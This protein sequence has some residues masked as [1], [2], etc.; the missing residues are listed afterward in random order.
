M[1][2]KLI[3]K[4]G[5]KLGSKLLIVCLTFLV[6]PALGFWYTAEFKRFLKRGQ[7]EALLLSAQAVATLLHDRKDLFYSQPNAPLSVREKDD[8]I[9]PV[10][11]SPPTLDGDENDWGE[12]MANARHFGEE[13]VL[14]AAKNSEPDSDGF[15][16]AVGLY[17][18]DLS[19]F[20][21]V[22]DDNLVF[23]HPNLRRLD[24]CDQIRVVLPDKKGKPANYIIIAEKEGP[25]DAYLVDE[26]WKYALTKRAENKIRGFMKKTGAGYTVEFRLPWKMVALHGK[27]QLSVADVDNHVSR[28]IKRVIGALGQNRSPYLNLIVIRSP[29]LERLFSGLD[30]EESRLTI[31]DRQARVRAQTGHGISGGKVNKFSKRNDEV[32]QAA[33]AGGSLAQT[34][35]SLDKSYE[36][37]MAATPIRAADNTI[38]GV[39][40]IERSTEKIL[41]LKRRGLVRAGWV[42]GA[43]LLL[44]VL[45]LIGFS[46]RLTFRIHRLRDEV[47]NAIDERGRTERDAKFADNQTGDEIGD[48]ARGFENMKNRLGRYTDF[49]ERLPKTLRHEMNNPLNTVSVSL[50]NMDDEKDDERSLKYLQSAQRGVDRLKEIVSRLTEAA[51][52]EEALADEVLYDLDLAK[53]V[54][55]YVAN[56][57][58]TTYKGSIVFTNHASSPFIR[59]SDYK[60]EQLLDKLIDN[61][62][63]FRFKDTKV[64]VSI[65][66]DGQELC[67]S[68]ANDGPIIDDD[69]LDH[70]FDFLARDRKPGAT[71]APHL[72][73]GLYIAQIIAQQH[74]GHISVANKENREGVVFTVWFPHGSL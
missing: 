24:N 44:V 43:A 10:F 3:K 13:S 17:R 2:P 74:G 20:V 15:D 40:L 59:G 26:K 67:L 63:D 22:T 27:F 73:I 16:L 31:I 57:N 4:R 6:I 37:S 30:L 61:A 25:I 9:A 46:S 55:R 50:Q 54:E 72:G 39:A 38:L 12:V 62:S 28:Q 49:L 48:L 70:L 42:T 1:R 69:L 65:T 32:I 47:E 58:A 8:F 36:I 60:I 45:A 51:N 11:E 53:L 52:M 71:G 14:F 5:L 29:E 56:V 66:N 18:D 23:R 19:V 34:A 21:K 33:L 41:S 68:V 7:E 64:L 35:L